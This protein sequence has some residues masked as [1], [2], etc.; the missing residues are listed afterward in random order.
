MA[1]ALRIMPALLLVLLLGIVPSMAQDTYDWSSYTAEAG[2]NPDDEYLGN[3]LSI[4]AVDE[5]TVVF[6]LCTPDPAF[7]AKAAFASLG[8]YPSEQ[9]EAT[10]GGG[11]ELFEH[12]IGTGPYVL[13]DWDRGNQITLTRNDAYWGTPAVEGTLV[14]RWN[15]EASIR[16]LQLQSG[17]A[18]G[19]DNVGP[20]DFEIV[21]NDTNLELLERAGANVFYLG[22]NNTVEPFN[23][24]R[25][26]Q[27]LAYGI[28]RQ[29]IVSTFYPNGSLVAGQ[30][31][32]PGIFGYTSEVEPFAYD[33][34]MARA[35]LEEAA[36]DLGFSLPIE[37]T[38]SF[39]NVSRGYLPDPV[40]VSV[41]LQAQLADLG[42]NV[43]IVEMESGTFL[44][45]ADAGELSLHMLGWGMDYPDATNFLDY[46][47]GIGSSDQFGDKFEEITT[48]LSQAA[49]L[50]D[51]DARYQ[52]Y[53]EANTAIRDLVPMVPIAHGGSAV[54]YRAELNG[55]HVSP[56]GNE[57]FSVMEDPSDDTF[58]WVQNGEPAG[59]YCADESDGEALRV[60]QQIN[61]SLLAY[62]VGGTDVI[63]ALAESFEANDDL[64]VWTFHLRQ[65]VTFH[66]GSALD[67]HD[68]VASYV[69]QW[70]AAHPLHVGRDGS[71]TYFSA[72]FGGFLN[73]PAT[74]E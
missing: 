25:V 18:D 65:G 22:I 33:P 1:K 51:A 4:E 6:T 70:D 9:L 41:D 13:E 32:P 58:T 14:F 49:A 68:V 26:R 50:A 67:S 7:P 12:P 54:A 27:A 11:P 52:L 34:E 8:I 56:L 64:T 36:A 31:M 63:P 44:D 17:E 3:I 62:E 45:A 20:T 39:R 53:I 46:H 43:E 19:I 74:E 23:D 10:G 42:I 30:F 47:F 35:L 38:L 66:D 37:T 48:P 72:Y 29:R 5:S 73:P 71:F 40:T 15:E 59:L 16:L 24:V 55:T 28:D 61:E 60:C 21:R 57:A 69:V 2:C